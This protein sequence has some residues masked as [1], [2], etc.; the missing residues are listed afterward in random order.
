MNYFGRSLNILDYSLSLLLRKW[1]KNCGIVL[2]F[3]L[4]IFLL[5]SFQLATSALTESARLLLSTTPD[6]TVQQ[7]SAGRQIPLRLEHREKLTDIFGIVR[8]RERIWGYYFDEKNG[9]N[10]T[11]LGL[12]PTE[13]PVLPEEALAW[14]TLPQEPR[15]VVLSKAVADSMQL[16]GRKNFSLFRPDLSMASFRVVGQFSQESGL[17]SDDLILMS[18]KDAR[19][20]FA[21][22]TNE[23]TDL[24]VDAGNPAEIDTIAGKI[25]E[26]IPGTRVVTRNQIMKTYEVVFSWRSGIGSVCL[27]AS[28]FA[29][30]ILAWDKASGLSPEDQRE[31][32]I[33]KVTGWQS[34][35]I[36]TLR[37]W[38]SAVVAALSLILGYSGA[39]L[40]VAIFDA[41]L[42]RPILLGWS[43]LQPSI[44]F[45][46]QFRLGDF[47]LIAALS[48]IPYLVATIIPAWKSSMIRPDSV[49]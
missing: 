32:A 12:S 14:G 37:F 30:I 31:M 5:S 10:Y 3:S 41:P 7:M 36:M 15:D 13:Q 23:I 8:V 44:S 39:W 46:P 11:V 24:L 22:A 1:L 43:V 2:V 27:L 42:L 25:S 19:H 18:R 40:H 20:L 48:L 17:L 26:L 35:D 21:M 34:G 28:L 49:V 47:F 45:Y 6:I 38:E 29:F 4:V 9:A 16:A 33:L